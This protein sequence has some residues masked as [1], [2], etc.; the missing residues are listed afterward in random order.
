MWGAMLCLRFQLQFS[1]WGPVLDKNDH[2]LTIPECHV[3]GSPCCVLS[4]CCLAT[5]HPLSHCWKAQE[6]KSGWPVLCSFFDWRPISCF[7][8]QQSNVLPLRCSSKSLFIPVKCHVSWRLIN[9][10]LFYK[11]TGSYVVGCVFLFSCDSLPKISIIQWFWTQPLCHID[12]HGFCSQTKLLVI[13]NMCVDDV[14]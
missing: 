7:R 6:R 10:V 13:A 12:A 14:Q 3:G 5:N 9:K 11:W 1:T 4:V 8:L 2:V